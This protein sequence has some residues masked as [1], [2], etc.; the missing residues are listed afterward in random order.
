MEHLASQH[1]AYRPKHKVRFVTAAS[2]F[3][4]HDAT[5]NCKDIDMTGTLE[6]LCLKNSPIFLK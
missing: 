1:P 6:E 4:G 5:I 2:L 3:D